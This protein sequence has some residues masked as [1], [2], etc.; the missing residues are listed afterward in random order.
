MDLKQE[1]KK[2]IEEILSKKQTRSK[3]VIQQLGKALLSK[4]AE[5]LDIKT[6]ITQTDINKWNLEY[7]SKLFEAEKEFKEED[8]KF[9]KLI[10]KT[11]FQEKSFKEVLLG[12]YQGKYNEE[13]QELLEQIERYTNKVKKEFK[14][15]G[16]DFEKWFNYDK[17]KEFIVGSLPESQ[18]KKKEFFSRELQEVIVNLLG[19][20][21]EKK[22][23]L[24]SQDKAKEVFNKVFKKQGIQFKQGEFYHPQKG[25]LDLRD[26]EPILGDFNKF[27]EEIYNQEKDERIKEQ[28]GTNLSHLQNLKARLPELSKELAKRGYHLL[29]KLWDRDPGHDI[30]QGNYTHCCIA[31]EN[32]NR[33]AILDYLSDAGMQIVEIKDKTEDR[34]IA[35][36][37]I[38]FTE[39]NQGRVNLVLDNVEVNSDYSGLADD[40]RDNLFDYLKEY[41]LDVCPKTKRML[42]GTAYNDIKTSD[43]E[44]RNITLR[45]IGGSPRGTEYLDAFGSAWVDP[46]KETNKTLYLVAEDLKKEKGE[47]KELSDRY[48]T[49][50]IEEIDEETLRKILEVEQASF[51]EEMQSDIED[52]RDTLE[53]EKGIQIITKNQEGEI[54]SYLSSKSLEDAYEELR[55]YDP[56]LRPEKDVLYVESI[57]TKPENR[58][59]KV[60]LRTLNTIKEEAKRKG[61]KKIVAHVRVQNNLSGLLQ[62]RGARKL[63]TVDNWHNFREPF[64]YLEMEV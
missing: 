24:L 29:I 17:T 42:L 8:K 55:N 12:N 5:K 36:T 51:P 53:N 14:E 44:D 23:G 46:D 35:Q 52:L 28:I 33:G 49:Q 34:T 43:L 40:I 26:I 6:E 54:V 60:L 59:I 41:A 45:K 30:F 32:F 39:D 61:Y 56:E 63:R 62:K 47:K 27:I 21:R 9:L 64:D 11:E 15:K 22:K 58:D 7:L 20:Y 18:T 50:V 19:S 2:E 57:A 37:F 1:L 48:I 13:E 16:I 10:M 38:Y 4:F 3:E 25:K 31:V